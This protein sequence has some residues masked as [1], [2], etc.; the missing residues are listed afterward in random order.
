VRLTVIRTWLREWWNLPIRYDWLRSYLHSRGLDRLARR[1]AAGILLGS[2]MLVSLMI[3]SAAGPRG[4]AGVAVAIGVTIVCTG[5]SVLWMLRWPTDTQSKVFVLALAACLAALFL[6]QQ[7]AEIDGTGIIGFS[8]VACYAA[9][10]HNRRF[11]VAP[12]A[13]GVAIIGCYFAHVVRSGDLPRAISDCGLDL[14]IVVVVPL[15]FQF[16]VYLL[17]HDAD[18]SDF[19]PLTE[20]LNRRGFKRAVGQLAGDPKSAPDAELSVVMI[21][22][23]AFK[24]INDTYGHAV[25]DEVLINVAEILRRTCRGSS[26]FARIGG[27]EFVIAYVGDSRIAFTLADRVREQLAAT[28]WRLTASYGIAAAPLRGNDAGS[29]DATTDRL[30]QVADELMY[31][32]KRAGGDQVQS[33]GL[34]GDSDLDRVS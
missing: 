4:T 17:S 31:T 18:E 12:I 11:L 26:T 3:F 22:L 14:V 9:C 8:L 13:V 16:M 6:L 19:D 25:G 27:E 24:S 10:V 21:D 23:D 32:A 29:L 28:E 34:D 33:V 2:G 30:M 15:C 5:F 1:S 7:P 20:L